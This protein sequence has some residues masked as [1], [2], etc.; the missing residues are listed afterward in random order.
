MNQVIEI[1]KVEIEEKKITSVSGC[2]KRLQEL[3][4]EHNQTGNL[5]AIA[6]IFGI[7]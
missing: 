1:L 6:C 5:F 7:A 4:N 2:R 3:C